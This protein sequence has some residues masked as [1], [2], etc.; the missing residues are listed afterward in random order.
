[1]IKWDL[2]QGYKA[3]FFFKVINSFTQNFPGGPGF[4]LRVHLPMQ[5]I[6]AQSLV[7][8]DPTCHGAAKACVTNTELSAAT[9]EA[10]AS[11]ALVPQP[12]KAT[13][14]RTTTKSNPL[15]AAT[16]ENMSSAAKIQSRQN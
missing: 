2:F 10:H 15:H 6:C 8:E 3:F 7:W 13:A 14:M 12:E 4:Q 9:T 1:M 5:G 16:R 11:T